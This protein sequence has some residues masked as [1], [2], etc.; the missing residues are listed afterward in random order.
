MPSAEWY[1]KDGRAYPPQKIP[2][3]A[4]DAMRVMREGCACEAAATA[5]ETCRDKLVRVWTYLS[6]RGP[7]LCECPHVEDGTNHRHT[8]QR[9]EGCGGLCTGERWTPQAVAQARYFM[10]LEIGH[11]MHRFALETKEIVVGKLGEE[12]RQE[13]E[14]CFSHFGRQRIDWTIG[15]WETPSRALNPMMHEAVRAIGAGNGD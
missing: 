10:A 5:C 15:V 1:T 11:M 8:F 13:I 6:V 3:G 2:L 9:C 12:K 14:A 7:H 4:A